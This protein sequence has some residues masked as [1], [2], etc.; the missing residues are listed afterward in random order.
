[1]VRGRSLAWTLC[2]VSV[3]A[4]GFAQSLS[5]EEEKPP[6]PP[7]APTPAPAPKAP[8]PPPVIVMPVALSTALEYPDGATGEASVALELTL[9]A[10]GAVTK[11]AAIEG[12]E[13]FASRAVESAK[14]WKFQP[15]TR[16]GK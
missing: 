10:E 8:A 6:E 15:A 9:S 3:S 12:D 13:P 5:I 7:P 14:G 16:D 4:R 1:M 2:F 11:A